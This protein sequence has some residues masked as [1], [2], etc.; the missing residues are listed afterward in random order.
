M[1]INGK[2]IGKINVGKKENSCE[3]RKENNKPERL[4]KERKMK[5]NNKRQTKGRREVMN[6]FRK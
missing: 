6:E 5:E 3:R 4:E 2:A 1:E